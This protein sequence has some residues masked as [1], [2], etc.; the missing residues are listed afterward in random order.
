MLR[1]FEPAEIL[2][3]CILRPEFQQWLV[4]FVEYV[5]VIMQP[6]PH[7]N[8]RARS[9]GVRVIAIGEGNVETWLVNFLSQHT[10][11]MLEI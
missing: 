4:R 9:T 1:R 5:F 3:V 6:D 2:P 7:T 10:Q 11:R 8:V